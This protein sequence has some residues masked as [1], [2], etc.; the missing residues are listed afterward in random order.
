MAKAEIED[1][2]AVRKEEILQL[3]N[4]P[5]GK[6]QFH[7]WIRRGKIKKA[8]DLG[9]Y[10]LL[11]ATRKHLGLP[12]VDIKAFREKRES[13]DKGLKNRQLLYLATLDTTAEELPDLVDSFKPITSADGCPDYLR[14]PEVLLESEIEK[15]R[16]MRARIIEAAQI[17]ERHPG[18]KPIFEYA[19]KAAIGHLD[20]M[21]SLKD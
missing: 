19:Y 17:T 6:T 3:F 10:F 11:N 9:G 13:V 1:D 2:I 7:E 21:D 14:F 12:L 15:I 5:P 20:Y 4:P 8:R 18:T 16:I